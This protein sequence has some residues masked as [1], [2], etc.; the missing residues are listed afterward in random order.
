MKH[1]KTS[2]YPDHTRVHTS[3]FR[4]TDSDAQ[5]DTQTDRQTDQEMDKQTEQNATRHHLTLTTHVYTFHSSDRQTQMHREIHRQTDRQ[6]DK[7]T[8]R[9]TDKRKLGAFCKHCY[10]TLKYIILL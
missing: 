1:H 3:F 4:Q 7:H 9:Q 6:T 8:D 5:R 2:S 10:D